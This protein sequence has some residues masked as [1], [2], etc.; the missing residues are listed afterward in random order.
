MKHNFTK[1][2]AGL[3]AVLMIGAVTAACADSKKDSPGKNTEPGETTETEEFDKYAYARQ[4]FDEIPKVDYEGAEYTIVA[5]AAVGSSE[6][7]I[8]V[9]EM[10]AEP[11]NDAVFTRNLRVNERFNCE[12]TLKPG[13]V[14]TIT[15]QA[16]TSGDE[17]YK[18]SFPNLV[19][20]GQMAQQG[21]F[22]N[23]LDMENINITE[24]WWDQGT[25]GLKIGNKVYFM[26]G[27]INMLDNDVT[28]IMLFNKKIIDDVN[29][30]EPYQLVRDGKWTID[31]FQTMI[32]DVTRDLNGDSKYD[33]NDMY[34]Y[35][36]T[37]AGPTTF[38]FGS[39]LKYVSFDDEGTP[40]LDVNQ[41]KIVSLLEKL[42]SIFTK[43]NTTRVPSSF[44]IGKN[45]FMSDQVLF[46]GE[47]LSY[48]I[49][50]R[51]METPFGVLPIPKYDEAQL[52]Y[53]TFCENNASTAGIPMMTTD[54]ESVTAV[55]EGMAIQ[56]YLQVTPAYY[57]ISLQRKYTRDD[58][59]AEMLDIAL[60]HRIYDV[61]KV[62]TALGLDGIINNL[63]IKGSTDFSS[64]F[65][66]SEKSANKALDK[67]ISAFESFDY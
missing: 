11:I 43:D 47:V 53:S 10:D 60:A 38:F 45:M 64:T 29:L 58:E 13:D 54:P 3:L 18:L 35:V 52:D 67:I 44:E 62:Y 63:G 27:D 50:V 39:G 36:T 46:Y 14:S 24:E 25:A 9:E 30:E 32:R 57:D 56:S 20:A 15:R 61:G 48:I 51:A 66:R 12:I 17:T 21:Y 7:E 4:K 40:Y 33:D 55:L 5:Q 26:N 2:L 31:V 28:F 59:S 34:G 23:Y 19:T 1:I 8:W 22:L 49:N 37:G 41:S 6:K 16:V 65:T 42:A